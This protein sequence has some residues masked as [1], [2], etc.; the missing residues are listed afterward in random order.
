MSQVTYDSPINQF[1]DICL[2]LY[3]A[4]Q[5]HEILRNVK[6]K[7]ESNSCLSTSNFF[8]PKYISLT[9]RRIYISCGFQ[10][11]TLVTCKTRMTF[12][13]I[14][15]VI[16]SKNPTFKAIRNILTLAIGE[17]RVSLIL[18]E[19]H[20]QDICYIYS[21]MSSRPITSPIKRQAPNNFV[22]RQYNQKS[23]HSTRGAGGKRYINLRG[24]NQQRGHF[25]D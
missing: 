11:A 2:L 9:R 6:H 20:S 12:P 21:T 14:N 4:V 10:F 5:I 7:A 3:C 22:Q 23:N 17:P 18:R 25:V 16:I 24:I 13:I 1:Q 8:F 19:N 15:G